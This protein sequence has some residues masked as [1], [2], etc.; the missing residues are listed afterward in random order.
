M[1]QQEPVEIDKKLSNEERP[2]A[3][4]DRKSKELRN[5]T[6]FLVKVLW[7][8]HTVEEATWEREDEMHKKYQNLF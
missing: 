1:L 4:L 8:N 5:K 3:I 6:I 2:V 7:R